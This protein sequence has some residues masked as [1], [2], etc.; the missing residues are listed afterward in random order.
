MSFTFCTVQSANRPKFLVSRKDFLISYQKIFCRDTFVKLK[1]D[2]LF[3]RILP[4]VMATTFHHQTANFM[5]KLNG[6]S[7]TV[8]IKNTKSVIFMSNSILSS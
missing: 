5:H 7:T 4:G 1:H 2:F 8:P 6:Y 3:Q